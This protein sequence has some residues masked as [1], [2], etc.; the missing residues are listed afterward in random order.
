MSIFFWMTQFNPQLTPCPHAAA[1][2][3]HSCLGTI[4]LLK[5]S[6]R[7]LTGSPCLRL[8]KC[9]ISFSFLGPLLSLSCLFVP[10]LPLRL[11][12][13]PGFWSLCTVSLP[14]T[15]HSHPGLSPT[16]SSLLRYLPRR[17]CF[18]LRCDELRIFSVAKKILSLCFALVT[19]Q[20]LSFI[21]L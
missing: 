14:L 7:M 16:S 12:C 6:G 9:L 11:S 10:F 21:S 5:V 8:L 18:L 2:C 20:W 15:S 13:P 19:T 17:Y 4:H 1:S 3:P